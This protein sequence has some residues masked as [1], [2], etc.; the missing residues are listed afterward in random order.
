VL[1]DMSPDLLALLA[2][3]LVVAT[4]TVMRSRTTLD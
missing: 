3:L 1:G 4:L 2:V